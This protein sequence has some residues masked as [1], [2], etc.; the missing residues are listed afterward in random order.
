[1]IQKTEQY[2]TLVL[3]STTLSLFSCSDGGSSSP[4][5]LNSDCTVQGQRCID[6]QCGFAC[7]EDVDCEGQ[8]VCRDNECA[9]PVIACRADGDCPYAQEC[10]QGLCTPIEGFCLRNSDCQSGFVCSRDMQICVESG[11][12]IECINTGDCFAGEICV[13]G[14]CVPEPE[15]ACTSSADCFAG[16]ICTNGNCV[17][18]P[19]PDCTRNSDCAPMQVCSGG[20][21]VDTGPECVFNSDC[22][23]DRICVEG[24]CMAECVLD[25]DCD[26]GQLCMQGRCVEDTTGMT[27]NGTT[28]QDNRYSG[29]FRLSSSSG[30]QNCS[31]VINVQYDARDV[32]ALQNGMS[33]TFIF[34]TSTY[35]GSI[36]NNTFQVSWSGFQQRVEFC[37]DMNTANTYNGVF[38]NE[39]FFQGTLTSEAFFQISSC[40]CTLFFDITGTRR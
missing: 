11:T 31:G 16:E 38:Q 8:L 20:T 39:N 6:G 15:D 29:Q 4:C 23:D 28:G 18:E 3:I 10:I 30:I 35:D 9:E 21:C 5:D 7:V 32:T 22:R 24:V 14:A 12:E 34:P 40:N 2:T 17:P 25:R 37:G 26:V 36:T 33:Y 13:G 1:M 27:S 19:E